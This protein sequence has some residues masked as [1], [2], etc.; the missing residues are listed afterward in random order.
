MDRPIAA[1]VRALRWA[2]SAACAFAPSRRC[3]RSRPPAVVHDR[4][5]D[6]GARALGRGL[7]GGSDRFR[8]GPHR[9]AHDIP[10][11]H[12]RGCRP[13]QDVP[14]RER[15]QALYP[16]LQNATVADTQGSRAEA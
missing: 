9:A 8:H 14:H 10:L 5:R 15:R 6:P 13:L 7:A 3:R 12:I 11:Y 4:D 16:A 2:R 1:A